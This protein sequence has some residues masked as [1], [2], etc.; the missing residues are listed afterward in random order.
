LAAKGKEPLE[1]NLEKRASKR[2]QCISQGKTMGGRKNCPGGNGV[3]TIKKT[4]KRWSAGSTVRRESLLN[5][6]RKNGFEVGGWKTKGSV[7]KA[8]GGE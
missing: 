4:E 1:E 5:P 8:P 2:K 3:F 6:R 7:G